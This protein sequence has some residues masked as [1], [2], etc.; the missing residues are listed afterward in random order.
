MYLSDKGKRCLPF[1]FLLSCK[2]FFQDQK[3]AADHNDEESDR[4]DEGEDRLQNLEDNQDRADEKR[5]DN[6]PEN[7]E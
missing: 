4:E 5:Q 6:D 3:R 7:N 2:Y 1:E